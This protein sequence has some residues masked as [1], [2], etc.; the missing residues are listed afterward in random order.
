MTNN[1]A[2]QPHNVGSYSNL[3]ATTTGT[4]IETGTGVLYSLTFNKPVATSVVTLYDGT[5]TGGTV[6]GTIT[7]PAN[8]Q[9]STIFY[10]VEFTTG[11]FVVVAT[12]ASDITISY[13]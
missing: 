11:L 4:Q 6:I 2:G 10:N 8:P 1:F 3:T 13:K 7:I 5:S 12:A 9:P